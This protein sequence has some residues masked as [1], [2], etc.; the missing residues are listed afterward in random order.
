MKLNSNCNTIA[1]YIQNLNKS[2]FENDLTYRFPIFEETLT[3][4]EFWKLFKLS[5]E[6]I[7]QKQFIVTQESKCFVFTLI[8]YFFRNEKF[9]KS[10]LIYKIDNCEISLNKGLIIVGGF[11]VGKTSILKTIT[12]MIEKLSL[13]CNIYPVRIHNSIEIVEQFEN[14]PSECRNDII[15]RFSKG[16]RIFDDIKNEREASN[17]GKVDLFKEIL[18]KRYESKIFR[19]ILLCNYDSEFPND[20]QQ[21]IESFGR[22]GDRNYDRLFEAFNFIELKEKSKRI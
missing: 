22:Y 18:Y 12:I 1:S 16:F 4:N 19:T 3:P 17:Y 14:S 8:Y 20:M 13:N 7:N 2:S 9:Y 5:F 6:R 10:P 15:N 21:A 11:G